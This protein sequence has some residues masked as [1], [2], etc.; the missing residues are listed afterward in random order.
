MRKEKSKRP[1][2]FCEKAEEVDGKKKRKEK[3]KKGKKKIPGNFLG[4]NINVCYCMCLCMYMYKSRTGY[5]DLIQ[6]PL[7]GGGVPI[8]IRRLIGFIKRKARKS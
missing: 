7:R 1:K 6:I 8:V 2:E 3:R 5:T 4:G